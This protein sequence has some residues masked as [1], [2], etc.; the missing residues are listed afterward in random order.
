MR[1]DEYLPL[2]GELMEQVQRTLA[3]GELARVVA[4]EG[5]VDSRTWED[6]PHVARAHRMSCRRQLLTGRLGPEMAHVLAL[7]VALY[8]LHRNRGHARHPEF[9]RARL[10]GLMRQ[11]AWDTLERGESDDRV[12]ACWALASTELSPGPNERAMAQQVLAW[13]AREDMDPHVH[14]AALE[15]TEALADPAPMIVHSRRLGGADVEARAVIARSMLNQLNRWEEAHGRRLA[16]PGVFVTVLRQPLADVLTAVY[17]ADQDRGF[18]SHRYLQVEGHGTI[19]HYWPLEVVSPF[20][21]RP[22]ATSEPAPL[23]DELARQLLDGRPLRVVRLRSAGG[24]PLQSVEDRL[25]EF[26][27]GRKP[28]MDTAELLDVARGDWVPWQR[29]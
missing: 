23:L 24:R 11:L 26:V 13:A 16:P 17:L 27:T 20:R 6:L 18:D 3:A 15:A 9:A 5:L 1:P 2:E 4:D 10:Q 8:C 12:A 14:A 21:L 28:D 19:H 29:L 25:R 22:G 7:A